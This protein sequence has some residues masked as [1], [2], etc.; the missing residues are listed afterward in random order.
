MEIM[1][2]STKK[3]IAFLLVTLM[4]FPTFLSC[5]NSTQNNSNSPTSDSSQTSSSSDSAETSISD[6]EQYAPD[7]PE[8]DFQ[9]EI[10]R[11]ITRDDSMHSYSVHT[12]DLMANELNGEVIN[13]VVYQR[14][15]KIEE[16]Y[17]VKFEITT[18]DETINENTPNQT[19]ENAVLAGSDEFD[20]LLTHMLNGAAS[21]T[22]GLYYNWNTLPYIDMTKPYWSAG[23]TEGLSVGD[24]IMLALSDLCVSSNDNTHCMLFNK[25]LAENYKLEDIYSLVRDG[26]W[27]FDVFREM[28]KNVS[29]DLNGD[30]KMDEND[31]YGYLIGGSSG[32]LNFLWAGGSQVC[33]KD[34]NNIPFLDMYSERTVA[35]YDFLY[36]LRFSD[37]TYQIA[38]WVDPK[39]PE[40]FAANQALFMSTQV[41]VI[42]DLRDMESDFGI[43]PYPKFDEAQE[44]YAHYVDGHA[45]MMAVPKSIGNPEKVGAIIEALSYESYVSLVPVYYDTVITNKMSRD[46]ESGEMLDIIYN[47]RVFDFAYCY[48]NWNLS[49]AFSNLLNA[50]SNNFTSK[51]E[52]SEKLEIKQLEKV[53]EVYDELE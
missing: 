16:K 52:K 34:E 1:K 30:S 20:L 48:D 31:L 43:I 40:F 15:N 36:E 11:F 41:G 6:A 4:T 8:L 35:I 47:T 3:V 2:N 29:T 14:N 42:N 45:T 13:D 44:N 25:Q 53:I 27:T 9:G 32:E 12:R 21:V 38:S 39:C 18:F 46:E 10:F 51:Y 50:K 49:F 33:S 17:N 5:S 28:I 22:R 7:I 37:D 24:K 26:K 19:V 23:A